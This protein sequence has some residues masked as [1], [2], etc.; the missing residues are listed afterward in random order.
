MVSLEDSVSTGEACTV[1]VDLPNNTLTNQVWL[2]AALNHS[3]DKLMTC[4]RQ[5]QQQGLG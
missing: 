3:A 5:H 2:L 4:S 1:D